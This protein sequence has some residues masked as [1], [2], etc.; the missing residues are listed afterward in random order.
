MAP[1]ACGFSGLGWRDMGGGGR[2]S[3]AGARVDVLITVLMLPQMLPGSKHDLTSSRIDVGKT[4]R[5]QTD[6]F[7]EVI[8]QQEDL[9]SQRSTHTS[10]GRRWLAGDLRQPGACLERPLLITTRA[11]TRIWKWRQNMAHQPHRLS[12]PFVYNCS[13]VTCLSMGILHWTVFK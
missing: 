8:K 6:S 10:K 12:R 4:L 7:S 5:S 11:R 9:S 13:S 3:W 1:L 2:W